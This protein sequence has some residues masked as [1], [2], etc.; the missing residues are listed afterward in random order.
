MHN[1]VTIR[2]TLF[3]DGTYCITDAYAVYAM[4]RYEADTCHK[5]STDDVLKQIRDK[6]TLLSMYSE[7]E[8]DGLYRTQTG[9]IM[10]KANNGWL[11]LENARNVRWKHG[12]HD[13][14]SSDWYGIIV[15]IG[16]NE[17]PL[18]KIEGTSWL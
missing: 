14:I 12:T 18:E 2:I 11:K 15:E 3:D 4:S 10:Q 8:E 13:F 16:Q 5:Q 9:K 17:L 7:P 6:L 1:K